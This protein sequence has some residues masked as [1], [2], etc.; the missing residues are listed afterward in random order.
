MLP[1]GTFALLGRALTE[2]GYEYDRAARLFVDQ[3]GGAAMHLPDD[4]RMTRDD[5]IISLARQ[6]VDVPALLR[7][8]ERI[9][10]AG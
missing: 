10:G 5:A 6:G 9:E 1:S 3:S 2:L 7:A 8:L 4:P